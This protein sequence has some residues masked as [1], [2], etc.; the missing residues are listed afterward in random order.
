MTHFVGL[1]SKLYSFKVKDEKEKKKAKGI[2]KYVKEKCLTFENYLQCLRENSTEFRKMTVIRSKSHELYT[3][4]MNKVTLNAFD[5][6]RYVCEDGI[7]TLAWGHYKISRKR[8]HD[9]AFND[10]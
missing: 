3:M 10:D 2:T 9:E 5:D 6:K 7:S 4:S 8:T 1:R